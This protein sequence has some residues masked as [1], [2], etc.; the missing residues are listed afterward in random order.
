MSKLSWLHLTDLHH[1]MSQYGHLWPNIK[2]RFFE[3]LEKVHEKSGPWDVVFFTGDL[4]QKGAREEFDGLNVLLEQLWSRLKELGSTPSLIPIPGNH[5]LVRPDLERS[6]EALILTKWDKNEEIHG[7]FWENPKSKY[8]KVI[9]KAFS[10]YSNWLKTCRFIDFTKMRIGLIPG[11]I[12][13]TVG[14]G[15]IKI[16][17]VGLNTAFLQLAGGNYNERLALSSRQFHEVCNGDGPQWLK[18][19]DASLL[20]THHPVSWLNEK[21]QNQYHVEIAPAGRFAAH[22]FGHMHEPAT[23]SVSVDGGPII[24]SWQGCS[25]FGLESYG[26]DNPKSRSHGYSSGQIEIKDGVGSIRSW[27]RIAQPHK[28]NGWN[29]IANTKFDLIADEGTRPETLTFEVKTFSP[30]GDRQDKISISGYDPR[31]FIGRESEQ[32]RFEELLRFETPARILAIK[33]KS[34]DG[35]SRLLEQF[36]QRCRTVEP[37]IPLSLVLLDQLPDSSPLALIQSIAED[38]ILCGIRL[39]TYQ[40]KEYARMSADFGGLS[41]RTQLQDAET[42]NVS[43][44]TEPLSPEQEKAARGIVINSFFDDL[45]AYCAVNPVVIMLDAFDKCERNLKDWLVNHF[46]RR[47]FFGDTCES[48]LLALVIAGQK[49]P[50]FHEHWPTAKCDSKILAIDKLGKWTREDLAECLRAYGI[51]NYESYKLFNTLYDLIDMN[52]PL[53][54]IV[55]A[56]QSD[57]ANRRG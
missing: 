5:D 26:E 3:D 54:V 46:L 37:P 52:M 18:Q 28:V 9:N 38:L 6:A 17:V 27:P 40:A 8:R 50:A 20:L 19:H 55:Q 56:I 10:N 39:D 43:S 16:G 2:E 33:A 1:G 30:K 25:L 4:V 31:K 24:R 22:L 34:G 21:S 13:V 47:N 45:H 23:S 35:K 36:H 7:Q 11:D 41:S 48:C 15:D 42:V 14:D 29:I 32:Q 44:A 53:S 49:L 12:S 57:S 51:N